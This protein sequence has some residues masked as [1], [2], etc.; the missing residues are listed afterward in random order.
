MPSQ[1]SNI[2]SIPIEIKSVLRVG[3]KLMFTNGDGG[4]K[5]KNQHFLK[6]STLSL[7][8]AFFCF[9]KINSAY[10]TDIIENRS[11]NEF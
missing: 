11:L 2:I 4:V 6:K 5:K 1:I 8:S 10:V 9:L 7:A 3:Y